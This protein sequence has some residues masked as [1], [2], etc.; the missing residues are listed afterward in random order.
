MVRDG[1]L[2]ESVVDKS[3]I[4]EYEQTIYEMTIPSPL[5]EITYQFVVPLKDGSVVS[6]MRYSVRR[7]CI[8]QVDSALLEISESSMTPKNVQGASQS[9]RSPEERT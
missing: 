5:V 7:S 2:T 6:S 8:P 3:Y 9:I 1:R 4:N